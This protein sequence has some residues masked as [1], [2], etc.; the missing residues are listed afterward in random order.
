MRQRMSTNGMNDSSR[1][2]IAIVPGTF[3]PITNGHI[4]IVERSRLLFGQVIVA[5]ATNLKKTPLFG[6]DER[7][8]LIKKSLTHLDGVSIQSFEGL[9]VD[10]ARSVGGVAIVRGLRAIS[11]FEYELQMALMNRRMTEEVE[12]VF[13]MPSEE[14][15]FLTSTIIKEIAALGGPLSGLVPAPVEQALRLKFGRD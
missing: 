9:L 1:L 7:L 11:D 3:D 10:Y 12:T 13:M 6:L 4:D 8:D 2:H 14:Y 5:V 15:S